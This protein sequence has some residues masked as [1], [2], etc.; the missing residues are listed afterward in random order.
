MDDH[1]KGETSSGSNESRPVSQN[2][3]APLNTHVNPAQGPR[4]GQVSGF[5]QPPTPQE[6]LFG[7]RSRWAYERLPEVVDTGCDDAVS[8]GGTVP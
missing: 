1:Y 6:R 7:P 5:R 8:H 4:G 3:M 2:H